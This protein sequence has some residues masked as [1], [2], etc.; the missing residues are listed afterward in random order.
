MSITMVSN[1]F[2]HHQRLLS[3][4]IY[5]MLGGDYHFIETAPMSAERKNLGYTLSQI[6]S[7]VYTS[8]ENT[9][10]ASICKEF[11][12]KADVVIAGSVPEKVIRNRICSGKLIF[13]Y[14]ERPLKHGI[15][16]LKYLPRLLRWYW[17]NPIGKPIYL[18][19]S[20]A[21]TYAD[22]N[23]F[24]LFKNRA[25]KWGYFPETRKY[26]DPNAFL[27]KKK[28]INI[29]WVGRFL[30]WKHP[31]DAI[32]V[33]KRLKEEGYSFN[34]NFIGAGIMEE[35]LRYMISEYHL[36]DCVHLL[37]PMKPEQVRAHMEEAGIF[38]FTSDFQEGWGAVLNES[39]NSGC[40][41]IASHAIGA[42][43]YLVK[44]GENGLI[45]RFGNRE[46]LYQKVKY[47]L[48]KPS[49]QKRLGEAAYQTIVKEWNADIAAERL[50]K[51]SE[52]IFAGEK[53]PDLFP[54]GPCSR[55]EIL[56]NDWYDRKKWDGL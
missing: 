19:C 2:N 46:E 15:E 30:S 47:L 9:E 10:Q 40:A 54:R 5:N 26:D 18:L 56:K 7:Y 17:C 35:A 22:Y 4:A 24:G 48:D 51:L 16:P 13:R 53:Y 50:I 12:C 33:A 41:V 8:H 29:L 34:L 32:F 11:I 43:P 37:G 36:E 49:E 27:S 45:Y 42:V 44:N 1:Y 31:D 23:R 14:S 28:A 52:C 55:A 39:M 38:L 21:Y 20:S 6:P 3:D 25:Y